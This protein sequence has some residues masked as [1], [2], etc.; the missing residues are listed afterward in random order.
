[1]FPFT[2]SLC[3][4]QLNCRLKQ[5]FKIH[6]HH[7][8]QVNASKQFCNGSANTWNITSFSFR[9]LIIE[10]ILKLGVHNW[11]QQ[12]IKI[13]TLH[14]EYM[15]QY[16]KKADIS[17][18]IHDYAPFP[19]LLRRFCADIVALEEVKDEWEVPKSVQV[20]MSLHKMKG[21]ICQSRSIA[22]SQCFISHSRPLGYLCSKLHISFAVAH[23]ETHCHPREQYQCV[24]LHPEEVT[25]DECDF[26]MNAYYNCDYKIKN[27]MVTYINKNSVNVTYHK[28]M[29]INEI[30]AGWHVNG[31]KRTHKIEAEG[32]T[33]EEILAFTLKAYKDQEI[34]VQLHG[35][36]RTLII[37]LAM[38]K[39]EQRQYDW[40][41]ERKLQA[42]CTDFVVDHQDNI[43]ISIQYI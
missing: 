41:V 8:T 16:E 31:R 13:N 33:Y 7:Y 43:H 1:M 3:R 27:E 42:K 12:V 5:C 9:A 36:Q 35:I 10:V 21:S 26:T 14:L 32:K 19:D 15:I 4:D 11:Y 29:I 25:N 17:I 20:I 6:L 37:R 2:R 38:D 28:R 18:Q 30:P 23:P 22:N 40:H 34:N 39:H 24:H